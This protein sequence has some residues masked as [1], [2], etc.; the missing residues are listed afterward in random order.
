MPA[1][2]GRTS[3]A[4]A[5]MIDSSVS[6]SFRAA[7][8]FA[9]LEPDRMVVIGGDRGGMPDLG[10]GVVLAARQRLL[11]RLDRLV[12]APLGIEREPERE[13]RFHRARAGIG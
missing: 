7:S 11:E 10:F 3:G 4:R 5:G 8:T 6:S 1:N 9:A 12:D 13:Q 2:T